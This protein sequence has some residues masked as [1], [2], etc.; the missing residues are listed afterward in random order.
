MRCLPEDRQYHKKFWDH[1]ATR[2]YMHTT[3]W[4]SCHLDAL[5][6]VSFDDMEGLSVRQQRDMIKRRAF[7]M[8][9]LKTMKF[10]YGGQ[11][12]EKV[13]LNGRINPFEEGSQEQ[14]A[15]HVYDQW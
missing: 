7:E 3:G 13:A 10:K 9:R 2:T 8:N 14:R 15:S 6:G 11:G 4:F 1:D 5:M 12:I